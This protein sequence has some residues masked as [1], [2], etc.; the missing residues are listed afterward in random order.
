MT[1]SPVETGGS[2]AGTFGCHAAQA[3]P[4]SPIRA[5]TIRPSRKQEP[6]Y[7]VPSSVFKRTWFVDEAV[8]GLCLSMVDPSDS[9]LLTMCHPDLPD[10]LTR[11]SHRKT[12]LA[13]CYVAS[14]APAGTRL[15]RRHA[16]CPADSRAAGER[17]LKSCRARPLSPGVFR[18]AR[19]THSRS[20]M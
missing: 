1:A 13:L 12:S 6:R 14:P 19:E 8:Y 15:C 3:M 4:V 11:Q 18:G 2:T 10:L 9:V 7:N 20:T 17:A 16:T 5:R